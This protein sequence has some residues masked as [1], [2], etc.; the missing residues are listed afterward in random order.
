[1]RSQTDRAARTFAL[2]QKYG[3]CFL[4]NFGCGDAITHVTASS[5]RGGH[6]CG[7]NRRHFC[8]WRAHQPTQHSRIN[9][10]SVMTR[11]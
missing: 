10:Q 11:L 9:R 7:E 1:M 8:D 4:R 6:E 5:G 3:K 2:V